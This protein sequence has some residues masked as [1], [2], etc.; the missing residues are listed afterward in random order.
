MLGSHRKRKENFETHVAASSGLEVRPRTTYRSGAEAPSE[1]AGYPQ[2][3]EDTQ[4]AWLPR[5]NLAPLP[6]VGGTQA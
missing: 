3:P 4:M 1:Q 2:I 6:P 5:A